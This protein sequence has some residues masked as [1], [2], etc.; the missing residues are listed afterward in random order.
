MLT[1]CVAPHSNI[2]PPMTRLKYREEEERLESIARDVADT[3]LYSEY[4]QATISVSL[5]IVMCYKWFFHFSYC[6]FAFKQAIFSKLTSHR[7]EVTE[8]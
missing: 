3:E 4:N 6:P 7:I 8:Q 2:R 5:L 1:A